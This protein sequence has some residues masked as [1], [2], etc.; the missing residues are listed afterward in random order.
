MGSLDFISVQF[1]LIIKKKFNASCL[2]DLDN[3]LKQSPAANHNNQMSSAMEYCHL[4]LS[5][6]IRLMCFFFR[7]RCRCVCRQ[8]RLNDRV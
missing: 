2:V 1:S 3:P 5:N 6:T 4:S 8:V 7:L